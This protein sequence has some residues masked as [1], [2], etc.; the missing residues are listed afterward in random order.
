MDRLTG[1]T[2]FARVAESGGFSAAARRL[3]MST[4]MVSNHVQALEAHLSA[5]LLNRTTRKV[6]LTEVGQAFYERCIRILADLDEA[7]R[8]AGE[9]QSTPRGTLRLYTSSNMVRF[10]GPIVAEYLSL[11]PE[12]SV[13]LA[14]GERLVDLVEEGIDLAIRSTP[15]PS[16]SLIVRNLA[17]WRHI[18]CCSPAYLE[19]HPAPKSPADLAHHNCVRYTHYPFGDDWRF[20][21]VD[22]GIASV[23]VSGNLISASGDVLRLAALRG[24]GIFLAPSFVIG[25]EIET[26]KLVPLLPD[27]RPV[28]FSIS[29]IYPTRHHLSAKVRGFIDLLAL[30]IGEFR[31]WMNPDL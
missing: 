29:A 4:T 25:D 17:T 24:Q 20:A 22:G 14:T 30:R 12:A 13:E 27:F 7:E 23:R 19:T 26:G 6:S 1:M 10:I 21:H 18:L 9:L 16:S 8:A 3:N 5:R 28:E 11:Y 31:K 2:V 15:V